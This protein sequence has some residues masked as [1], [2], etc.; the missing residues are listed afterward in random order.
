MDRQVRVPLELHELHSAPSVDRTRTRY[1]R[2]FRN[3]STEA[4]VTGRSTNDTFRTG[5]SAIRAT[6]SIDIS[7]AAAP[8]R[9]GRPPARPTAPNPFRKALRVGAGLGRSPF[10]GFIAFIV[11]FLSHGLL[12][13]ADIP[14]PSPRDPWLFTT[15]PN[16]RS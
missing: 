11:V 5:S 13:H 9:P 6:S 1:T 2:P 15:T 3:K 10:V 7:A 12:P 8:A 16:D 4:T 14:T